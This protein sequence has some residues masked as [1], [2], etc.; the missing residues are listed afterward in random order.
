MIVGHN[1]AISELS[2]YL[3]QKCNNKN[4]TSDISYLLPSQMMIFEVENL[5][6]LKHSSKDLCKFYESI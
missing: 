5:S 1:P 2:F 4:I 3:H 6:D